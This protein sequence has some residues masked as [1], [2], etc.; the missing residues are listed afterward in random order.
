MICR[1]GLRTVS[2]ILAFAFTTYAQ[3]VPSSWR[4]SSGAL[5]GHYWIALAQDEEKISFATGYEEATTNAL[6]TARKYLPNVDPDKLLAL[7]IISWPKDL[8]VGDVV[9]ALDR[10]YGTPENRPI[11]IPIAISIVGMRTLGIKESEIQTRIER[12]RGE[13]HKN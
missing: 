1:M 3:G 12:A 13:A 10:F 8:T 4:D 9:T 7:A 11:G 5:N 2:T 6:M